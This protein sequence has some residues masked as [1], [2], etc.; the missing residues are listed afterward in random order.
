MNGYIVAIFTYTG[1]MERRE[2]V[3]E[4]TMSKF[5]K[6][7]VVQFI[8]LSVVVLILNFDV[9]EEKL[10]G[11]I[12]FFNGNYKSFDKRFYNNLGKTIQ[13]ALMTQIIQP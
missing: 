10:F 6:M 1:K 2:T 3:N 8:N 11:F 4:E 13:S 7:T 9:F 5:I 12:N